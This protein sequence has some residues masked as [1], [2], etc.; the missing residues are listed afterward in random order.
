MNNEEY[1]EEVISEIELDLNK[2]YYLPKEIK[3]VKHKNVYLAIYT[4][5]I[6]WVVLNNET[7]KQIFEDIIE[8]KNLAYL[9]ENYE[10]ESV[11]NVIMQIEAKRFETPVIHENEENN[12]YIYLTNN[13]NQRCKHCYMYAGD[14]KIEELTVHE[15]C[16]ILDKLKLSGIEGVTFT[17]GEVTVFKGF[18][19]IVKYAHTIGLLVTVLS[20]G[21]LWTESKIEELHNYIDEIQISIDG[22]DADSYYEVRQHDGFRKAISCIEGFAKKGNKVSMAV[23]PLFDNLDMFIQKFEPFARK[24]LENHPTVF[25]K[26]NHELIRGREL[27]VSEANNREY[28]RKLKEMVERLY[29][30][31]YSETFVLNYE[32]KAR[33]TNCGFGGI[34]IAANGDVYWCNRIHELTSKHNVLREEIGDIK[35]IA[36]VIKKT[37]SVDNTTQCKECEIRYICGGG[38]RMKYEGI[39]D[40]ESHTGEWEYTCEGK[41]NIYEKMILSN[42]YFFEE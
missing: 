38:C 5:G 1:S 30:D 29:P 24:F 12:V 35:R 18:E 4:E 21:V 20:N 15:W 7:E 28:R 17:G 34:S 13:C 9:L 40:A 23:T 25:I 36:D 31:Y 3:V 14:I 27:N 19:E 2:I 37:T 42:E 32:N 8:K 16:D 6:L 22:Y 33:R 39:K 11:L 41:E 10:E 26:V